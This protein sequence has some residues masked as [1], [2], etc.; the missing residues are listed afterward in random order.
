MLVVGFTLI[1][2]VSAS[3]IE[4]DTYD[5][6]STY[7]A[8]YIVYLLFGYL[9]CLLVSL[10]Y[11][12]GKWMLIIFYLMQSATTLPSTEF[13]FTTGFSIYFSNWSGP[14]DIPANQRTG[15]SLNILA[16]GMMIMTWVY[17]KNEDT[18]K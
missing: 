17:F 8:D 4:Y 3:S 14:I 1:L 12:I 6:N 15:Y 9:S 7:R 2:L 5:Y 18:E 13:Y 16:I 10:Q 11:R